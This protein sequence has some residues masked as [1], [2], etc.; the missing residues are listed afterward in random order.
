MLRVLAIVL[1]LLPGATAAQSVQDGLET[2]F[3]VW[4]NDNGATRG[5]IAIWR[6]GV[7]QREVGIGMDADAPVELASLSKAVTALCAAHL[8]EN[9]V[10]TQE[11]TSRDVLRR[12]PAGLSVA[13][14][15]THST[16]LGPDATQRDM[17]GWLDT[18]EDRAET[19]AR[20][21]LD[22]ESQSGTA[23]RHAYNNENYAILGAMIAAEARE[24]YADYC[25]KVVLTPAGVTTA[26]PSPRT[27]AMA[28]WGGWQMSVGDYARLMHWAYGPGGRIGRAPGRWPSA[29]IGGGASYGMG[30]YQRD[31]LGDMN[32]W[33]FGALCFP[34]RLETGSYAVSW[35]GD[36]SVVVAY[37]A[38]VDGE[39]MVA[40]DRA[41]VGAVFR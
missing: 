15:L 17:A 4:M 5:A 8:I 13:Q 14:L 28:A 16:G 41:L 29:E 30:M 7:S 21:A 25:L 31:F 1:C 24:P 23:G 36:W 34:G 19:A 32:Y 12:G 33:H 6:G 40:L 35:I 11:T 20:N 3:R 26:A 10:W 18:A 37:D 22:R 2:A 9:R 38:C 27:G 39:A